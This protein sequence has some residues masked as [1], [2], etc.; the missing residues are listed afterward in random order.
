VSLIVHAPNVHYGGG[1][2]LLLALLR[3]LDES[4]VYTALLDA[5]LVATLAPARQ[6]RVI[7]VLPTVRGRLGAEFE[8]RRIAA[9][10]DHVLCFG[11]L[12]PL[13][14]LRAQVDLYLQNRYLSGAISPA[15][16]PLRG[17]ARIAIEQRWLRLR[18][19][20]ADRILVQSP[21]MRREVFQQFGRQAVVAPF[22]PEPIGAVPATRRASPPGDAATFLYVASGEPHKNHAVLLEA[23]QELASGGLFPTLVLTVDEYAFP[24]T[25]RLI[26]MRRTQGLRIQNAGAAT[27]AEL[28]DLYQKADALVYPSAMES[29][30]LP[31]YEAR[32]AGLPVIAAERDYVRDALDPEQSFDPESPRSIARAVRRFILRPEAREAPPGPGEF[33]RRWLAPDE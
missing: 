14:R 2:K 7:T 28:A 31:L 27:A 20:N 3:S 17:R 12:P 11:N 30:G 15:G 26:E 23:W 22:L 33:V 6:A 4:M 25:A 19:N 24:A 21:S 9:A 32:S 13:F 1:R 29:L 8:L 18:L 5:R 16:W 10:G